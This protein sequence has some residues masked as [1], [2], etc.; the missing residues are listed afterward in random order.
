MDLTK[1]STHAS[2]KAGD[3]T[4]GYYEAGEP[5]G[6]GGD[7]PL[8]MLH[9]GGPGASAWS[10]FGAALPRFARSFRTVLVDQPWVRDDKQTIG[11]L[12]AGTTSEHPLGSGLAARESCNVRALALRAWP[13]APA[14]SEESS[15]PGLGAGSRTDTGATRAGRGRRRRARASPGRAA[16]VLH[17]GRETGLQRA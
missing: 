13:T 16:C 15:I 8:V 17:A 9:G 5:T 14:E 11:E 2:A 4:L 3:I 7:L 1:E 10:N 6:V 12:V